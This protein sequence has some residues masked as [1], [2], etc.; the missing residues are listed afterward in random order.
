MTCLECKNQFYLTHA[1]WRFIASFRR[2]IGVAQDFKC[3][4][5]CAQGFYSV[6]GKGWDDGFGHSLQ[7]GSARHGAGGQCKACHENCSS[8]NSWDEC[9]LPSSTP[10]LYLSKIRVY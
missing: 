5:E 4:P 8:C 6:K 9:D 7:L 2:C 3:A 1:P 10:L